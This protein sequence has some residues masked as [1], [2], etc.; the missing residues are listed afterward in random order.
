ME[1]GSA[2]HRPQVAWRLWALVP[3]V[4]LALVVGLFV[5][6]GSSLT[7]LIGSNPPAADEFEISRVELSPGEIRIKVR[8]PQTDDLTIGAVTVDD[9]IVP[10]T[11]DGPTTL[12]RLRSSTIVVAYDWVEE[13]P[14]LVGVT[15]STGVQTTA[16]IAAAVET[17]APS[18]GGFLG[19]AV[20]GFLVAIVPVA[21]GLLWLP[22]LRRADRRW[23]TAFMALTAGL[24]TFLGIDAVAE[25]F[26]LQA[27]LPSALGG[28]GLVLLGL[29][30]SYLG[31]T[32]LSSRLTAGS[33]ATGLALALLVAI[34]IGAHNLGEG[35]AIGTSFAFGELQLGTFLIVGFM[36]HNV[37]E[38][39]GIAV[40]A[41]GERV[42]LSRLVGLVAV[43]GVPA[44][45]G[46]W[47]G[48]YVTSDVVG[49]L[50]FSMAAGAA[51]QVVV[52]VARHLARTSRGGL[53]SGWAIGGFLAGIAAMWLTGLVVG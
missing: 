40:P 50:F 45:L 28:P 7:D 22:A 16:E 21:L 38:G 41:A 36:I 12:S 52:E 27:A 35:L 18:L 26:E 31:M 14:L 44:I 3:I 15:S 13:E 51:L 30:G 32:Y 20:V 9:A 23:L 48:G 49:V 6:W 29:A 17:P 10:F 34:G 4:L 2:A 42:G 1:S 11:V 19:Y 47:L 8:N 24:L 53:L 5:S 43:A 37:T 25:A 33:S 46:A 39:L